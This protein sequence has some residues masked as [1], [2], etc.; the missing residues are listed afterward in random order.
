[1]IAFSC[2]V[3]GNLLPIVYITKV[4]FLSCSQGTLFL[5]A[6]QS[7]ILLCAAFLAALHLGEVF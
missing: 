2:K 3:A 7:V 4:S 5:S 6:L 1:M